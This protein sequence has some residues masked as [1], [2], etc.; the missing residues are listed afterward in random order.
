MEIAACCNGM[1]FSG[2]KMAVLEEIDFDPINFLTNPFS[3]WMLLIAM[4]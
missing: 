3:T 2:T 1:C 4:G